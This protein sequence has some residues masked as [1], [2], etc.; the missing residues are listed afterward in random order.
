MDRMT[1]QTIYVKENTTERLA[2]TI[3]AG[4]AFLMPCPSP[5]RTLLSRGAWHRTSAKELP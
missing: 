2:L 4:L 3:L 5:L 1:N